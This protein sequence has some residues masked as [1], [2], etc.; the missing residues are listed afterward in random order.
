[1]RG[2]TKVMPPIFFSEIVIAVTLEFTWTIHTSVAIMG[3]FFHKTSVIL[4]IC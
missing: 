4:N 2:S 3:P 1:M